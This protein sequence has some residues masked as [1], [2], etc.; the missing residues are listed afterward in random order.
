MAT[1]EAYLDK[2]I[3]RYAP[4]VAA[5]ALRRAAILDDPYIRGLITQGL[6]VAG[7]DLKTGSGQ[8]VLKSTI[9]TSGSAIHVKLGP[10]R[11]RDRL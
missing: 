3:G 7:V 2:A 6:K 8:V 4:E 5:K 11:F 1:Q 10:P 9:T